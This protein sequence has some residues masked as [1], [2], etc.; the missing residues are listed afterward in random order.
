MADAIVVQGLGKW[1]YR[2]HANRPVTW[3]EALIRGLRRMKPVERFWALREVSFS[4]ATGRMIGVVGGNG[5][6]KSTLL[7][8]I[9]GVG[10]PDTGSVQ[11]H[12][13]I[14]A[15]LDLGVGFQPDLSG[16]ENVFVDGVIAG[17]TRREIA[18]CFESIVAFAELQEFIESPLRTYST[19][20]QMRL[21]FA[22][23]A[24][25]APEIL[26]ID[27][28]L[29]VGDL[30]FQHKCLQ[31]ITRLKA[32]GHT[33]FLVSHDTAL[34]RQLCD[35]ALWLHA[36]R[37]MAHGEPEVVVGQYMAQMQAETQRRRPATSQPLLT[38][39]GTELRV[40]ENRFGSLELEIIAVRLLGPGRS[41]VT[42]VESG[43]GLCVELEYRASQRIEAP[44]FGVAIMREDGQ[45]CYDA[46]TATAGLSFP[47]LQ[48]HG[49]LTLYVERLDLTGGQ[50]YV[51]VGAY[52][53]DWAYAYD[54]HW[55]AYP[56]RIAG[57]GGA[58]G[59]LCPPQRWEIGRCLT[60][61]DSAS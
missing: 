8:L 26:L 48:G 31:W 32:E 33:I 45:L 20:M 14:G 35:E 4:I 44:I 46:N 21:A 30:L 22:I 25:T 9:G 56:L 6:G 51:D 42:E 10:R 7:R 2:Y 36:G 28:V 24:H 61:V 5:A 29:A 27:E 3:K 39:M 17:L 50:Y 19:G 38:S 12:G 23:A 55:H 1:F 11:V 57:H 18:A 16:R 59:I 15:L 60:G 41:P 47:V 40:N 13:R 49:R 34:I 58:K 54:Y 37:L 53:R 43:D 52:E